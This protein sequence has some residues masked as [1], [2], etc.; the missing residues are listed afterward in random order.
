M[1]VLAGIYGY[2][3]FSEYLTVWYGSETWEL[4]VVYKLFDLH[5]QK[6]YEEFFQINYKFDKQTLKK[7]IEYFPV[8]KGLSEI[9]AYYS[10]AFKC[11]NENSKIK[12]VINENE[13]ENIS[14]KNNENQKT[15]KMDIPQIIF[16]K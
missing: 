3:T 4:E 9:L 11:Q 2:F 12:S 15:F 5:V 16:L 7:I 8:E 14:I 10:I 6:K 13:T 1:L